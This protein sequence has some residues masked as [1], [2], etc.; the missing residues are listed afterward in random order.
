[1]NIPIDVL[2]SLLTN[3]LVPMI[4]TEYQPPSPWPIYQGQ[5]FFLMAVV[6]QGALIVDDKQAPK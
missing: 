6:W 2:L 1:M 5:F 4:V 3:T